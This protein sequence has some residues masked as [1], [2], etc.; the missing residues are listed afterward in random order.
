[1][2]IYLINNGTWFTGLAEKIKSCKDIK[3]MF[4]KIEHVKLGKY[5]KEEMKDCCTWKFFSS[6]FSKQHRLETSDENSLYIYDEFPVDKFLEYYPRNVVVSFYK[7][8]IDFIDPDGWYIQCPVPNV[9]DLAE[10]K[11]P[12]MS[13]PETK[14]LAKNRFELDL[15]TDD[16]FSFYHDYTRFFQL[17]QV[18]IETIMNKI[19]APYYKIYRTSSQGRWMDEAVS[20]VV[21]Q[22]KE[23]F[24]VINQ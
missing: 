14:A 3:D 13:N 11:N 10:A 8:I 21:N 1:M 12:F 22:L 16:K 2:R 23:K 24:Y 6:L 19:G 4:G 5:R 9:L 17:K 7:T 18:I 20:D 15:D